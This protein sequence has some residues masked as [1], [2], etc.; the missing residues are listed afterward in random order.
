MGSKTSEVGGGNQ[1]WST[2]K[3]PGGVPRDVTQRSDGGITV[4]DHYA[5]GDVSGDG[6]TGLSGELSTAVRINTRD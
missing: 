3:G 5:S 6:A 1:R 4:T 2:D